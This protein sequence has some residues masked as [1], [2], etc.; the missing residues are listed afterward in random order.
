MQQHEKRRIRGCDLVPREKFEKLEGVVRK[1]YSQIGVIKEDGLWMPIYP[2]T[3]KTLGYCFIEY[4]TPQEAEL[5]KEKTHGYKL[6]RA[7][8]FAVSMFDD[9]DR[10]MKVPNE[11]APPE[12]KPYTPGENLQDWLTDAKARDQFVIRA[13]SDT[14]VLWND[15]RHLKP[16]PVYKRAFG[17]SFVQWSPL[18]TYLATVH[19]QGAA[20]WGGAASFNKLM[21]YSHP[22]AFFEIYSVSLFGTLFFSYL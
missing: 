3:E 6:D 14:E 1:I 11:W 21:R 7:H 10:F 22:Q 18:G 15:A 19:R 5:A 9:F 16:D 12:T 8:I 17:Q 4:N 13:G 2:E 20:V